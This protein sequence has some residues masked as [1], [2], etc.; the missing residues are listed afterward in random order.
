FLTYHKILILFYVGAA[1]FFYFTARR[2]VGRAAATG[3]AGIVV[4]APFHAEWLA[5]ATSD[6]TGLFWHLLALSSL[7]LGVPRGARPAWTA[8]CGVFLAFGHLTRPLMAP[9]IVPAALFPLLARPSAWRQRLIAC[10]ALVVSFAL[11]VVAWTT[12]HNLTFGL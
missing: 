11:P 10:F 12:F 1:I 9:F 7:L 2:C 4:F 8:A 6:A 5:V 3:L